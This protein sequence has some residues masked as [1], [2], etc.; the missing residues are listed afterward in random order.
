MNNLFP[1][2]AAGHESRYGDGNDTFVYGVLNTNAYLVWQDADAVL[3]DPPDDT[4]EVEKVMA[5]NGLTLKA[6]LCTHLHFDHVTGCAAWQKKT[7]LPVLAGQQDIDNRKVLCDG[8]KNFDLTISDFTVQTLQPGMVSFGALNVTVISVPGHSPG[9]L[10]YY[11]PSQKI[12]LSGD[13]LFHHQIGFT[14][15]MPL[16]SDEALRAAISDRL[17]TLPDD[18][19]VYPGH[20]E[21]TTIGEENAW[22][23]L[24]RSSN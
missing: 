15:I 14:D 1:C 22:G 3:V 13:T 17:L 9:S 19:K 23:T 11:F 24:Y 21:P 4:A 6:L 20:R 5:E 16:Q 12:L 10:C 7:G 2:Q 8:A 18:T